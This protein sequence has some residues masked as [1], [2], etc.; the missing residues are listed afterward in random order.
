[1]NT[2]QFCKVYAK[3]SQSYR[4]YTP[5]AHKTELLFNKMEMSVTQ[6]DG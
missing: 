2:V 5:I 3:S 4:K 1:M 6:G